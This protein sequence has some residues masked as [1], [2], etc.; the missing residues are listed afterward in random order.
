M[1]YPNEISARI[2]EPTKYK[3]FRRE[4]GKFGDGIDVIWGITEDGKTEVQAI[5]F[6]AGKYSVKQ[7]REW[8]KKHNY[9][10]ISIEDA[11]KMSE[12]LADIYTDDYDEV[13][14]IE[15]LNTFPN[16][17]GIDFTEDTLDEFVKN[18]EKY[19]DVKQPHLKIDHTSQQAVLKALTGEEYEE[20]TELPALGFVDRIYRKGKSLFADF[21]KIPR[22]LKDIIFGG[23]LFKAVSPEATF[24]FRGTGDKLITAVAL[25]NNPAQK[26]ILDVH[27]ADIDAGSVKDGMAIRYSGDINIPEATMAEEKNTEQKESFFSNMFKKENVELSEIKQENEALRKDVEA[28]KKL[29]EQKEKDFKTFSEKVQS[30]EMIARK[31]NAEQI[32]DRAL[33]D[34]VPAAVIEHFKPILF[35]EYATGVIK[36][37]EKKEGKEI[38]ITKTVSDIIEDFFAKYP[39]KVDFSEKSSTKVTE[40]GKDE[41]L[42]FSE[43]QKKAAEYMKLGM[44]QHEALEKAG[45]EILIKEKR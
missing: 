7:V 31:K 27:M 41:E 29:Y 18:F 5:R 30:M 9:S 8:I 4:N 32:C 13:K 10:A 39:H 24:N 28:L 1:P 44:S 21:T 40:P 19:K 35:A 45:C 38:E 20:G 36:L 6:N 42:I 15:I 26:H 12:N 11:K 22:K 3:K 34:G 2:N 17:K 16:T 14:E 43:I 25:T 23:K 33:H 37:S